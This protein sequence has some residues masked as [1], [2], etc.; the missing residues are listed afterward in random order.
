MVNSGE[1]VTCGV[2]FDHSTARHN[3][4]PSILSGHTTLTFGLSNPN[5]TSGFLEVIVCMPNYYAIISSIR[6]SDHAKKRHNA[7]S[8]AI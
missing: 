4:R 2:V 6:F 7:N 8:R 5:Y 1:T 3:S